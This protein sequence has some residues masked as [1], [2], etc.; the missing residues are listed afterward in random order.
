MKRRC[1]NTVK[2]ILMSYLPFS[3]NIL[4]E[5]YKGEPTDWLKEQMHQLI[6]ESRWWCLAGA[7]Q[8]PVG[9]GADWW[10]VNEGICRWFGEIG[11]SI[12]RNAHRKTQPGGR[13]E[14]DADLW[15]IRLT[16]WDDL[17]RSECFFCWHLQNWFSE[18]RKLQLQLQMRCLH[19]E[20]DLEKLVF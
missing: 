7:A 2:P 10:A 16:L 11:I 9:W 20:S 13:R 17:R 1:I 8:S 18:G 6:R 3:V 5:I 15:S 12:R 19:K 4:S 14:L